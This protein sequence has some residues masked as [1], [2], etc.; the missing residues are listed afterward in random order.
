MAY[1][2]LWKCGLY[3]VSLLYQTIV[4]I[5]IVN[6]FNGTAYICLNFTP[7]FLVENSVCGS[8]AIGS[9]ASELISYIFLLL[10]FLKRCKARFRSSFFLPTWMSLW[11]FNSW[12]FQLVVVVFKAKSSQRFRLCASNFIIF[13]VT[14]FAVQFSPTTKYVLSVSLMGWSSSEYLFHDYHKVRRKLRLAI[15]GIIRGWISWCFY[16]IS[17]AIRLVWAS[18]L[19]NFLSVVKIP[20]SFC[21]LFSH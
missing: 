18:F 7:W 10:N 11:H 2:S 14:S 13:L 19:S 8:G 16:V 9:H 12:N 1:D 17:L 3:L 21:M 15:N 5:C 4:F 20:C 6:I